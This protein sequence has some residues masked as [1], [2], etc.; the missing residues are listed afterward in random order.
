MSEAYTLR[1]VIEEI[2]NT[3]EITERFSKRELVVTTDPSGDYPQLVKME[4]HGKVCAYLDNFTPGDPVA[5]VF[6]ING[7]RS[8]KTGGVFMNLVVFKI[9]PDREAEQDT[10]PPRDRTEPAPEEAEPADDD[11]NLPF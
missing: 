9:L 2:G 1:G 10:Q 7:R 11:G 8:R 4:A 3:V 5:V 6:Y